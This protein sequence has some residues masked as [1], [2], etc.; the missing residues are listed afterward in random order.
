MRHPKHPPSQPRHRYCALPDRITGFGHLPRWHP[1][2]AAGLTWHVPRRLPGFSRR[3]LIHVF[4]RAWANIV[5]HARL[6]AR[7]TGNPKTAHILVGTGLID[8]PQKILAWS[9]VPEEDAIQLEQRY[10]TAERWSDSAR[11]RPG[12]IGL[13]HVATHELLHA[14]GVLHHT[15]DE[16]PSLMDPYYDP[17]ISTPQAWE[18]AELQKRYPH[19]ATE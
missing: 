17:S 6:S 7:Y 9:Q 4:H 1:A 10:D 15:P 2:A 8:G 14:L 13:L 3:D 19:Y 18:I 5:P 12:E 16:T 11:P